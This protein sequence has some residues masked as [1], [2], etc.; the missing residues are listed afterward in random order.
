MQIHSKAL[1]WGP[2]T[3]ATTREF[4]EARF[5]NLLVLRCPRKTKLIDGGRSLRVSHLSELQ[6]RL[7]SQAKRSELKSEEA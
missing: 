2:G 7:S 1:R 4:R 6:Q 5:Y 3:A